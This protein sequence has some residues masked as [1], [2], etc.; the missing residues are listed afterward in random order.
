MADWNPSAGQV[1]ML[2]KIKLSESMSRLDVLA[3]ELT[4]KMLEL[5]AKRQALKQAEAALEA[6]EADL[7]LSGT[8]VGK[9]V[10]ERKAS[11][12]ARRS[13]TPAYHTAWTQVQ[14]IEGDVLMLTAE[15][16]GL[17][18]QATALRMDITGKAA[19]LNFLGSTS[20]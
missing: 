3:E 9:N 19:V 5:A 14:D 6:V 16:D 1:A 8:V 17:Q 15:I 11:L 13:D 7:L 20:A 4:A 2:G 12:I 18:A 10:E